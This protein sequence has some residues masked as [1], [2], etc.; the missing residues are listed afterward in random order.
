MKKVSIIGSGNV[1][2]NSAFFIAETAAANV[3]LVDI[4]EGISTGKALDLMEA[5]PIRQYRTTIEG[6]DDVASIAGSDVVVVTAGLVRTPGQARGENFKDNEVILRAIAADVAELTPDAVVIVATSPVDG[7]V[8]AFIDATGFDRMQVMGLGTLL[9]CTRMASMVADAMN[10]SPLDVNAVVIGSHTSRMVVLPEFTR[11]NGIPITALLTPEQVEKIVEDT[12]QAGTLIIE[13]AKR[14]SAY[15][16][17]SA[18]ISQMV[19]AIC[20]DT[21]KV[22][23]VS[24]LLEG[25]YGIRGVPLSVPCKLGAR[26]I[27]KILEIDFGD[28]VLGALQDSAEPVRVWLRSA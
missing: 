27:E 2:V 7:M 12:R 17:P 18:V 24:V 10:I 15:Y 23:P 26:G 5:G 14:H 3:T 4:Q 13:L 16:A 20:I 1:G 21:S 22:I 11:V 6:S 25:E 28:E 19:E 9:D 8:K